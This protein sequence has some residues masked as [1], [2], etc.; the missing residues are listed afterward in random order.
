MSSISSGLPADRDP[1]EKASDSATK[2]ADTD[3]ETPKKLSKANPTRQ[4]GS[5][6]TGLVSVG[7]CNPQMLP[8][9]DNFQG[10]QIANPAAANASAAPAA[11]A[12]VQEGHASPPSESLEAEQ[13]I[14]PAAADACAD[15]QPGD[16]DTVIATTAAAEKQH[17]AKQQSSPRTRRRQGNPE[18]IEASK[19]PQ[20]WPQHGPQ[21]LQNENYLKAQKEHLENLL[22]TMDE[23][24]LDEFLE[25]VPPEVVRERGGVLELNMHHLSEDRRGAVIDFI[26]NLASCKIATCC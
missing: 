14:N 5:A 16:N 9:S 10:E 26:E 6:W 22:E 20:Q 4:S 12:E 8:K 11:P 17:C 25:F 15:W 24:Y 7:G 2:P 18:A 1:S 21:A 13:V 19:L 23:H 3:S